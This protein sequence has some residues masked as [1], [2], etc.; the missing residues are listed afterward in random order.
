MSS[1]D[2]PHRP[3]QVAAFK[4]VAEELAALLEADAANDARLQSLLDYSIDDKI[5]WSS[6]RSLRGM[7]NE[8]DPAYHLSAGKVVELQVR[9]SYFVSFHGLHCLL[10]HI[11][12]VPP[13][14]NLCRRDVR[15]WS[16]SQRDWRQHKPS[17]C[18]GVSCSPQLKGAVSFLSHPRTYPS[19]CSF[20]NTCIPNSCAAI[21]MTAS[22]HC[23][24]WN[25]LMLR[26]ALPKRWT[27]VA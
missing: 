3:E 14:T 15:V 11:A 26:S 27:A 16:Q 17:R 20:R 12:T 7:R 25:S 8:T 5:R 10:L 19:I 2:G 24:R 4:P 6:H 13:I 18:R 22:F 9:P 23:T 21:G 1:V